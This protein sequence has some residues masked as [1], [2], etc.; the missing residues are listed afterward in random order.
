MI[1]NSTKL[2][3]TTKQESG[4]DAQFVLCDPGVQL[5]AM[6]I[7]ALLGPSARSKKCKAHTEGVL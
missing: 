3:N 5:L 7:S 6:A 1:K 2:P 4:F